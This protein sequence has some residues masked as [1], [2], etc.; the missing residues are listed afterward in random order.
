VGEISRR[1]DIS[2]IGYFVNKRIKVVF[3]K[4]ITM[5]EPEE[6]EKKRRRRKTQITNRKRTQHTVRNAEKY[7]GKK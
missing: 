6:A 5:T 2:I 4:V 3:L 7:L 1:R